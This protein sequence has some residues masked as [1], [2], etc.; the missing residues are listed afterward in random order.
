LQQNDLRDLNE[1]SIAAWKKVINEKSPVISSKGFV[2]QQNI[3]S[4][5]A[6]RAAIRSSRMSIMEKQ[7][8]IFDR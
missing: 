6:P 1:D 5:A 8:V 3:I 7:D 4:M 2:E